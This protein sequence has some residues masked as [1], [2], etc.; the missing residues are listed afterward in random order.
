MTTA[1]DIYE[2]A[3]VRAG[4]EADDGLLDADNSVVPLLNAAFDEMSVDH[5]WAFNY[6]EDTFTTSPGQS[7]YTP[8][9]SW[10]RTA[11]IAEEDT[12]EL[13]ESRNRR[14]TLRL[15][16]RGRPRFYDVVGDQIA[17]APTPSDVV[18]YIHAYYTETPTIIRDEDG[19]PDVFDQL[20]AVT[21]HMPSPYVT[22]AVL[23]LTKNIALRIKDRE[24]YEMVNAEI[25]DFKRRIDDN[26]RRQQA[27]GR[28]KTRTD[29]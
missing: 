4:L 25:T 21:V 23:F 5:D 6:T 18:S 2:S 29:I 12:G 24:L 13:L 3:R 28:I 9:T 8:P 26:R 19:Y 14:D 17:L 20:A 1:F 15:T 10:L 22:L 7:L 11:W 16:G 27:P